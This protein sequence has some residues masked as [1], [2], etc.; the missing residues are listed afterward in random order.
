MKI[1]KFFILSI[2]VFL[3]FIGAFAFYSYRFFNVPY[4]KNDT[5]FIVS[6]G[7]NFVEVVNNLSEK[8]IMKP[9]NKKLF[10]YISKVIYRNKIVIKAGEYLFAK[11]DTPLMIIKKLEKGEI[12]YRKLT[13]AE[14]LSNDSIFKIID[15][16][17]GLTGDLPTEEIEEGTLLPETYLYTTGETKKSLIV[18]MQKAMIQF[19]DEE[20]DKRAEDLPFTTKKEA[21]SL[22]SIIEKETGL[23]DERGKVASVFINRLKTKMRLQSDP[24]V[25]YAFTKGNVDLERPIRKSDLLRAS[26]YNTYIIKGIP[27]KPI[28]NPGKDA[29]KATLNPEKTNYLYFVATGNG[30]HNFSKTLKE[31]N[32]FVQKYRKVVNE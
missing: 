22:A 12:Y 24:T 10:F 4:I 3:I 25:V 7:D 5:F 9:F 13:F 28:A 27:E 32:E 1:L 15:S 6:K 16:T 11:N 21:L 23:P 18:R 30:G 17:E 29:I 2:F 14:G 8:N 31:H 26:E 20:W 19:F